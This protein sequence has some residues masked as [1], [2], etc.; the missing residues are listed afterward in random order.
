MSDAARL[1]QKKHVAFRFTRVFYIEGSQSWRP[2]NR[3]A[4]ADLYAQEISR[5][6]TSVCSLLPRV[7]LPRDSALV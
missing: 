6:W 2:I 5:L 7:V 1:F 4:R 3:G